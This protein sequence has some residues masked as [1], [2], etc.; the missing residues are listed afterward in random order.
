ME[1]RFTQNTNSHE[2]TH[3]RVLYEFNI[4]NYFR[5]TKNLHRVIIALMLFLMPVF[6]IGQSPPTLGTTSTYA[7]FTAVG[8][9]SNE[10]NSTVTGDV[11]TNAGAFTAFPPGVLVGQ[12]HVADPGSVSAAIDVNVAYSYLFG[13][14]CGE[15][16]GT[17]LGNGQVLT[18]KVYCLGA[19]STL[20]G[21]LVLDG[22]GDPNALFI[23]KIDGALATST[24][25]KIT[26]KGLSPCNVYWQINGAF[27]LG[28]SSVFVGTILANGAI[29]LLEGSSLSG[30]ALSREGA[31]DLHNNVVT[32]PVCNVNQCPAPTIKGPASVCLTSTGNVY[33]TEPGMTNYVWTVPSGAII[34]SGGT[35]SSNTVTITWN[36]AGAQ[37]VAVNYTAANDC[38]EVSPTVYNVIVT[39]SLVPSITGPSTVCVTS[40]GNVY[41]TEPGMTNYIWTVPSGGTITS[42]GTSSSNTVT[43]TWNSAGVQTVS[44][45]YTRPDICSI[46][47]PTV[48][49]V[50]VNPCNGTPCPVPTITG[51]PVV[52]ES[53]CFIYT[54]EPGM[55]DYVWTISSGG[56]VPPG[57]LTANSIIVCWN[58]VGRQTVSVNYTNG[59]CT[60]GSPTVY[61]VT[62][63]PSLVP[64]ITGLAE[65]C[66]NA[67]GNVYTTEP[68]MTNY[69]WTVPSGGTITSGGTPASNTVTVTWNTQGVKTVGVSYTNADNC[70][71]ATPTLYNIKVNPCNVNPCPVPTITG[72]AAVCESYCTVYTTE[73]GMTNYVWTFSSGG[74]VAPGCILG[75]NSIL[76]CWNTAGHQTVSVNY[77]N[78]DCAPGS[79]TVFNVIVAPSLVPAITGP[80]EVCTNATGNVYTTQPGMTNYVWTVPSGGTITSGGTS[81]SNTV[82]IT[83]NTAGAQTVDVGYTNENSCTVAIPTVYKVT[84]KPCNVNPCL[85]PTITGSAAVCET[86]C[87]IYTTEP[88]MTNY[89]WSFSSG[90]SVAPGCILNANSI[91]ICWNNAGSQTVSVNYTNGDCTPASPTV[92]KVTVAPS[93]VSSIA[94]PATVIATSTGN[95]YIT[96]PGMENYVWTV[97]SG[98]TITSGGSSAS[99]TVTVKWNQAGNQTVSVAYTNA[100]SC[101]VASPTVFKVTVNPVPAQ[102][103]YN[104]YPQPNNGHFTVSVVN[105]KD[106]TFAIEI[107]NMYGSKVYEQRN[108]KMNGGR[109]EQQIELPP[110][111][112]GVY[113]VVFS[114]GKNK[115]SKRIVVQK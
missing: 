42:G 72:S 95:V 56:S 94:G 64:A 87:I 80:S 13:L 67:T 4:L 93:M 38:A 101:T 83:W 110:L 99:N 31:I 17:T 111:A 108:M 15:T 78:G 52:C 35:S 81:A 107:Y 58:T 50:T 21:E 61:N 6:L 48:Y 115:V 39:S 51:S 69:L 105:P 8:A 70:T 46:A 44:V 2:N 66:T 12:K 18:P 57:C 24:N 88:G 14:T 53:Y 16:I 41:T 22:G 113:S 10:G 47:S 45:I 60:P 28:K 109:L 91:I 27:T 55:T 23:F 29:H 74:S 96:E 82:T 71:L 86:Y 36:T 7:L 65:V 114:S 106:E 104:L 100:N 97:S 84:V 68:G 40:P 25:S 32:I 76:I 85:A 1:Q 20:N 75:A 103:S 73:P 112:N 98:G 102:A 59:D 33:T 11:G 34:T 5:I 30:R 63:A 26:L 89:V 9:F 77:T 62:V 3:L 37:S 19:A 92:Y 54:T 49:N 79:P 90:G 43:V